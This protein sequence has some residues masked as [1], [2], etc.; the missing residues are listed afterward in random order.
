MFDVASAPADNLQIVAQRCRPP[1][2]CRKL[3]IVF[4]GPRQSAPPSGNTTR[5]ARPLWG[6]TT[7]RLL[8]S[9]SKRYSSIPRDLRKE[10]ILLMSSSDIA[11]SFCSL[12][13]AGDK[14]N[15]SELHCASLAISCSV[16]ETWILVSS[17]RSLL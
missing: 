13:R 16:L 10:V 1:S 2:A 15:L 9:R 5:H 14:P 12:G 7:A 17:D 6:M 8:V 11:C 3:A 4:A